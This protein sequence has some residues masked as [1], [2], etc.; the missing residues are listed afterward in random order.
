MVCRNQ[1]T[2]IPKVFPKIHGSLLVSWFIGFCIRTNFF[3]HLGKLSETLKYF[4]VFFI[5]VL[6]FSWMMTLYLQILL[7]VLLIQ[8]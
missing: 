2:W 1:E 4:I 8:V 7:K 6:F 3:S 5:I